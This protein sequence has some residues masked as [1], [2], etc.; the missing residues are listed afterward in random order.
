[1]T[2][3]CDAVPVTDPDQALARLSA[4]AQQIA[5]T[6]KH[7]KDLEDER[8]AEI[9]RVIGD[10]PGHG[11]IAATARAARLTRQRV[12]TIRRLARARH[13]QH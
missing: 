3:T 5:A 11:L 1:M 9:V 7:L 12:D 10:Q 2:L 4:Y 6:R 13:D 8:D